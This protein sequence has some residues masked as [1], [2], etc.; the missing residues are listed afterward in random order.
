[1][2]KSV[3]L[4]GPD[5]WVGHA[6]LLLSGYQVWLSTNFSSH[7]NSR[8]KRSLKRLKSAFSDA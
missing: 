4:L 2:R 8:L 7:A 6:E 1:M 5:Y 3:F